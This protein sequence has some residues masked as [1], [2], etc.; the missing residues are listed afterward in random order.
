MFLQLRL[1]LLDAYAVLALLY[2]SI[3]VFIHHKGQRNNKEMA[4]PMMA[5]VEQVVL[6]EL[7]VA[8]LVLAVA[9]QL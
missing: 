4:S 6:L 7:V 5:V 1:L 8:A 2:Q 3:D 9:A